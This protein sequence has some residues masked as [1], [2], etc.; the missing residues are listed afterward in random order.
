MGETMI[1]VFSAVGLAAAVLC[2]ASEPP[3]RLYSRDGDIR[4]VPTNGCWRMTHRGRLDW[5]L[6]AEDGA[7]EVRPGETYRVTC[8]VRRTDG[9]PASLSVVLFGPKG[10]ALSWN[11]AKRQLSGAGRAETTFEIPRGVVRIQAR[12]GGHGDTEIELGCLK[13]ERTGENPA[14]N[15]PARVTLTS[16]ALEVA[17]DSADLSLAVTDRRTGR[18]WRTS[19]SAERRSWYRIERLERSETLLRLKVVD[20]ETQVRMEV[21]YGFDP[22]APN[23]L[24]V[25]VA[26]KGPMPETLMFPKP[27]VGRKGDCMIL[28]LS[29]GYRLPLCEKTFTVSYPAL[30]SGSGSMAFFGVEEDATGAGWMAIVETRNDARIFIENRNGIPEALGPLWEP[31]RGAFGYPR[32]VC[33][34]FLAR[35]GYVAMAKRYRRTAQ[36]RGLVKTFR[37][38]AKERPRVDRLLGAANV[39]YFPSSGEPSASDMAAGLKAAGIDRFLWSSSGSPQSV[40][41]IAAM[42][43]VLVGRYDVY[44]DVYTPELV[45]QLGWNPHPANEICR[46]TSA[47]PNDVIWNSADSNDLRKAWGVVCKDGVKRH[48]AAQC[49]LCQ[50]ARARQLVA[51]ELTRMPYTSRFVDVTT[52]VGAEECENPAHPMTRTRSR[53]AAC[54]LLRL[55]GDEFG[56][57][58]GSEQGVDFAVPVCDYFEGMLSPGWCRMPHGRPGAQRKDIF[59]EGMNPTNV[60]PAELGRVVDF[61]LGE[62][63]RIPLFELVYHDCCCAHWYWFDYSN[64]PLCLWRKRDL[65]NALY[66]TAPMYIFDHRLWDERKEMFVRSYRT[67]C[68]IARKTGYSEMTDHR[69]LTADRS[70]QRSVFADGTVVTVNFGSGPFRLE[71]GTDL[72]PGEVWLNDGNTLIR[73]N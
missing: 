73:R 17:L 63:Y 40:A 19:A 32:K 29:E 35:G 45:R 33:Y 70:V 47:W 9:V 72:P 34:V 59:R 41:R 21:T 6:T 20:V 27:F 56:L 48:C 58:V 39:W 1:S 26:G 52:A 12:V 30:W 62:K 36:E 37:E 49:T 42:P 55:L 14:P 68:P 28:P 25:T 46:N 60:T 51:E 38:K 61:H 4:L 50:P 16:S 24:Q 8:P 13:L 23:E 15:V 5:S 2:G 22:A 31:E 10:E 66:G 69:A 44:R 67:V 53:E 65:F 57:V 64:R 43:D 54:E 3:Y 11:Y 71:D 7:M 18:I